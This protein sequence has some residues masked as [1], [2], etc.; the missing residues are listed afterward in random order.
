MYRKRIV[1]IYARV[2]TEHEAQISALGNQVQYYDNLLAQHPEWELYDRYIDEGITGTS[3][4]KRKNFM[5]MMKD[6][7]DGKFDL[8]ITR[9]VSRFARNTVDTLQQTRLLKKEGVEVYF[10]EDN[11]WTMNDE[12]GELRLTIMATL[13]Q[14]ESKK[15][16]LRVKAG[17]MISFQNAVPYGNGNILGY[18]RIDKQFVI[19]ESQAATVRRIFDLYLDGNGVR[20]IQFIIEKEGHLTA[21]GLTKWQPANIS[22]I[23]R[24]P[25]YCGTIVYRKQYVPDFLE[26]KKINNF[27]D[28][29]KVVVEGSHTPIITKEQF[30]KVQEMLDGKSASINNKGRRGKKVSK[31]VW[32][33][34]LICECGHTYNRVVWHYGAGGPQYAYQCYSQVRFGS[35]KTR[36]KKGLSTEGM[37]VTKMVARWKLE[38]MADVIFQKFWNDREGVLTIANEMLDKCYDNEQDNEALQRKHELEQK[39]EAWDRKYDNLLNMRMAGEIE[40]DRYDEKRTQ[41]QKE[42]EKLREQLM[43]L[44]SEEEITDDIYKDKLE[45]LKYGLEQDFNFSTKHIPE[46]IIDA[47]VKEIVVCRDCFI[48][49]LNFFPDDYKLD[50]EGRSNNYTVTQTELSSDTS[51]QHRRQLP[52]DAHRILVF[53]QNKIFLPADFNFSCGATKKRVI[54]RALWVSSS[55]QG[56]FLL[57]P[58]SVLLPLRSK[59]FSAI[60]G[61]SV[62]SLFFQDF[63]SCL[64][65]PTPLES[66]EIKGFRRMPPLPFREEEEAGSLFGEIFQRDSSEVSGA[67]RR[68]FPSCFYRKIWEEE[69][70]RGWKGGRGCGGG[71][72]GRGKIKIC[73]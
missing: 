2:S 38:A 4:K 68:G 3:V 32:C 13:A 35:V 27:G 22:R 16:S 71:G 28:V 29:D 58:L 23:L 30:Q 46:E 53:L 14:N 5:R 42:Q 65:P 64:P 63:F 7:S 52:I 61:N 12:D 15:T 57:P 25:F 18:D 9:E 55:P 26:Q 36:E 43:L 49:K 45:V 51:Q 40:K 47:F 66:P 59:P 11:I 21:T 50:V 24:N 44:E 73:I 8:V 69:G 19:N 48:W 34:K 41:L 60:E 62:F 10:T 31:D 17:Q 72:G 6:A 70:K 20:K 39:L 1:A 56:S 54:I 67:F 37:C 33:R